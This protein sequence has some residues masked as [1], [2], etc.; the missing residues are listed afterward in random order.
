MS[1]KTKII[2]G[3]V[4]LA[5][6]GALLYFFVFS[7]KEQPLALQTAKVVKGNVSTVVTATGT[8]EATRQVEVGTQVSGVVEKIYVDYNSQVKAGQLIAEL[9]K[10]NLQELLSQAKSAYD[11]AVNQQHYLQTIF[12]RQKELYQ[13][14]AIS[15]AD[16]Q[17]AEYNLNTAKGTAVQKLSDLKKAQTNLGYANI[18]SPIDGVVLSKD[19]DEGQTVAASYS[20]PTLF[21]IAQNLKQMQVEADVDEADIGNVKVGQRVVFTVDAFTGEEFNGQ[22]TQVRLNSTVTSNVVTY[23]VI[24]KADNPDEKLKPGLTAT[25]SIYTMELKDVLT[26]EAKAFSFEPDAQ[27]VQQ[28]NGANGGVPQPSEPLVGENAMPSATAEKA[29]QNKDIKTV[30]VKDVKGIRPQEVKVGKND[31]INYEIISGLNAGDEV[32]TSLEAA[33]AGVEIAAGG[34]SSSPFMP[35]PPGKRK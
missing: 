17:E 5:A 9:D 29:P 7:K 24:I 19:V 27:L 2:T 25:V 8:I 15:K 6:V 28:Y 1:N 3:I 33:V 14:S 21:T 26:L 10:E 12:S 32:A 16:Y 11:V 35:K 30:W 4:L 20:T 13:A 18:Y 22:V 23:T 31:G 34:D